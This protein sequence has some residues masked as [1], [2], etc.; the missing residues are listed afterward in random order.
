M[1][2]IREA[3]ERSNHTAN[4]N[5]TSHYILITIAVIIGLAGVFLRFVGT[6]GFID[7]AANILLIIGVI[8][9][10]KAVFNILK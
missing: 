7:L 8:I 10:L 4:A 6:W 9:A 2:E 1:S 3:Y 5:S